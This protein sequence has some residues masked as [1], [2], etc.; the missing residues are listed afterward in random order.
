MSMRS[1]KPWPWSILATS[2][3]A[4]RNCVD[5]RML[6]GVFGGITLVSSVE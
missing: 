2:F 1:T 3:A 6:N 4:L 5:P